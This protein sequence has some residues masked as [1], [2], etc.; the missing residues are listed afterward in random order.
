METTYVRNMSDRQL[1]I[2]TNMQHMP[3]LCLII[4][5]YI[6]SRLSSLQACTITAMITSYFSCGVFGATSLITT[7]IRSLIWAY[8]QLLAPIIIIII[9]IIII[10]I[11]DKNSTLT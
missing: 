1:E 9:I 5:I 8:L 2:P 7:T 3:K 6:L 10:L 4:K 11:Q